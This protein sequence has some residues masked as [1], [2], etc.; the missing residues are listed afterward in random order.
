L[1]HLKSTTAVKQ[2][3]FATCQEPNR[4]HLQHPKNPAICPQQ[5]TFCISWSKKSINRQNNDIDKLCQTT[6]ASSLLTTISQ[7]QQQL[8]Q[9]EKIRQQQPNSTQYTHAAELFASIE[10]R[11]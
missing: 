6:P 3:A 5:N 9:L 7:K 2:P 11:R 4:L 10:D 8:L 1:Q